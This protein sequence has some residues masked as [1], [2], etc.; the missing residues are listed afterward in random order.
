[1]VVR[2]YHAVSTPEGVAIEKP[3]TDIS[4][5]VAGLNSSPIAIAGNVTLWDVIRAIATS[6]FPAEAFAGESQP[7]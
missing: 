2:L 1:M 6:G 3:F 7:L 5:N 4:I